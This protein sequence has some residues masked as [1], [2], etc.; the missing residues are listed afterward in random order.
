MPAQA[1]PAVLPLDDAA[2]QRLAHHLFELICDKARPKDNPDILESWEGVVELEWQLCRQPHQ[3]RAGRKMVWRWVKSGRI[4][5][6]MLFGA[7]T[8]KWRRGDLIAAF[9]RRSEEA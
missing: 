2:L 4:P 6:P 5:K 1:P 3:K 8:A 7:R 9:T